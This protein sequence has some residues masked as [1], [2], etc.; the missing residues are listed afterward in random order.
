MHV[1]KRVRGSHVWVVLDADISLDN[2]SV[3]NAVPVKYWSARPQCHRC[4]Q[5]PVVP[6]PRWWYTST[7]PGR[8]P[9]PP[10][11]GGSVSAHGS[12]LIPGLVFG[13]LG[14]A[15]APKSDKIL[16]QAGCLDMDPF[17]LAS[18]PLLLV[19]AP[20]FAS[21]STSL[22]LPDKEHMVHRSSL[23]RPLC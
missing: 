5:P 2:G 20:R 13:S 21:W 11:P 17:L 7:V 10:A 12:P 22:P 1:Q 19:Q 15:P 23:P 18:R 16:R 8:V 4:A 3:W 14:K 9:F 6:S